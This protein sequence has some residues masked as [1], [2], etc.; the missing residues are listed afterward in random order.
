MPDDIYNR[1]QIIA[2]DEEVQKI[3]NFIKSRNQKKTDQTIDFNRIVPMPDLIRKTIAPDENNFKT[4]IFQYNSI[5]EE[6]QKIIKETNDYN[7][8]IAFQ[9]RY[10]KYIYGSTNW[11]DW[12]YQNW[13]TK[14][15][16]YYCGSSRDT[17]NTIYFCTAWTSPII[18]I[19]K[20]SEIFPLAIF[21]LTFEE[22][23]SGADQGRIK[24]Q[25]GHVLEIKGNGYYK[26]FNTFTQ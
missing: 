24:M 1:L 22:S 18:V 9:L 11:Y 10:N 21:I 7:E 2:N 5:T 3:R 23:M 13:G 4:I 25:N 26:F 19:K 15:N 17:L 8:R 20:L 12:A 16:A 14:W 6:Q